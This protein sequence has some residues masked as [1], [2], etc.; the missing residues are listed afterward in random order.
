MD[1]GQL[2]EK[3]MHWEA[4]STKRKPEKLRKNQMDTVRQDLKKTG[5]SCEE[6]EGAVLT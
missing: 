3:V 2:L 1:D 4:S 6:A 5:V